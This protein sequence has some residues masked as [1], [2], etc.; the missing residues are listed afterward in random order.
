MA[1]RALESD[2][3]LSRSAQSVVALST[4]LV[5]VRPLVP[6]LGAQLPGPGLV[7]G[8][9][10][11]LRA[12]NQPSIFSPPRLPSPGVREPR[13]GKN[14]APSAGNR[15]RSAREEAAFV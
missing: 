8:V 4:R 1:S 11:N 15:G 7:H 5:R 12:V 13:R 9:S 3:W 10:S 2:S 14:A 6:Q